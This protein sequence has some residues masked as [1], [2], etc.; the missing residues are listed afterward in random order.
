MK[1]VSLILTTFNSSKNLKKTLSS[2]ESQ[3]Y[4]NIEVII[5]DGGSTDDTV[6]IIKHY[7]K[8]SINTVIWKSQEDS[9]IY[10]AMNQG[11]KLCSGDIVAF[12][13][14][15]FIKKEA[16]SMLVGKLE[17]VGTHMGRKYVG[18]HADLIYMNEDKIVRKWKMGEGDIYQGWMPGHP[19][20]FLKREV[21][22]KYGLYDTS[23]KISG[24]YEFMIRVLKDKDN[25]LAYLSETVISM[26]YGGTSSNGLRSYIQSLKEGHRAL[27]QNGIKSAL[28][29]DFKRILKVLMQFVN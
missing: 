2:I 7:A 19:T 18:V 15:V 22:E 9:G 8:E 27:K 20:L 14:D 11:F 3:D 16:I 21:Y 29:I 1:K 6:N 13:N 4:P 10:D 26:F 5:K 25:K 17:E 24:D 23:Y 12:F 28:F